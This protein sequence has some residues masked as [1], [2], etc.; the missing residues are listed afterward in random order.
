MKVCPYKGAPLGE[1]VLRIYVGQSVRLYKFFR[2]PM[3]PFTNLPSW[4]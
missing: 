3:Q 1:R 2:E 4:T